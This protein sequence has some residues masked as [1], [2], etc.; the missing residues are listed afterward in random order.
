MREN[1][2]TLNGDCGKTIWPTAVLRIP[3]DC[4][5]VTLTKNLDFPQKQ[6]QENHQTL[7][8]NCGKSIWPT[9]LLRIPTESSFSY[10]SKMVKLQ[11]VAP[12]V[13]ELQ[14]IM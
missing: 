8:V 2:W 1:R 14:A 7:N 5:F 10:D 13:S 11:F 12:T 6:V 4:V 9:V 3:S